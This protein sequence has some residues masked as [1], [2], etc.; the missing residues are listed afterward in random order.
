MYYVNQE[1][2]GKLLTNV[3]FVENAP[4]SRSGSISPFTGYLIDEKILL[5]YVITE[6]HLA[7][8]D[9]IVI[10][11]D[12]KKQLSAD[13]L[14]KICDQSLNRFGI[15]FTESEVKNFGDILVNTIREEES[16]K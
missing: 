14:Y 15:L 10:R 4:L 12:I 2:L 6:F 8:K 7:L 9:G 11:K 1:T 3:N 16:V 5:K 13:D